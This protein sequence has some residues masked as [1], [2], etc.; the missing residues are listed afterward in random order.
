MHVFYLHG[1]ASSSQSKKARFLA[2]RFAAHGVSWFCPDFNEP[3]FGTLT[4]TRML[5]QLD[6]AI[7]RLPIGRIVLIGSSLGA[8]VALNA[9][10]RL[11]Q[12]VPGGRTIDRV[13]LLAPALDFV[14]GTLHR[15][16]EEGLARWRDSDRLDVFHFGYGRVVP[17][18][19]ALYSDALQYDPFS[20]ELRLPILMLQGRRDE[21]VSPASVERY[22]R[23]RPSVTL[24][25]LDDDHQLLGSLETI[26]RE[27][28][29]F[30]GLP[31]G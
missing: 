16:G 22:A 14:D 7:G 10:A 3:D 15:L 31:E 11:N 24:R 28:A 1:F 20:L 21:A 8:L 25:L 6:T 30:L 26:W 5:D 27:T 2:E 13:V 9:V 17:V 19:Y 4:V 23:G 18:G 12:K 29:A